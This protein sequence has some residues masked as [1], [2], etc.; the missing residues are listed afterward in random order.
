MNTLKSLAR[1]PLEALKTPVTYVTQGV[2]LAIGLTTAIGI[3][4]AVGYARPVHR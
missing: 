4:L 3:G 1:T 2:A